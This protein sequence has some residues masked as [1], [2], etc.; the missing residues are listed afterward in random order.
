MMLDLALRDEDQIYR[1]IIVS[2]TVAAAICVDEATMTL[3]FYSFENFKSE[4]QYH[5]LLQEFQII[6]HKNF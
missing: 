3:K 5:E 2:D 4:F 1:M 6:Q